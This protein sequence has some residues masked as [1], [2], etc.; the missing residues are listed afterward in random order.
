MNIRKCIIIIIPRVL[1]F[2]LTCCILA[3]KGKQA[4]LSQN[5][6]FNNNSKD[7]VD[8]YQLLK[9]PELYVDKKVTVSGILFTHEEGPCLV[10]RLPE[11]NVLELA[12]T[13]DS[14]LIVPSGLSGVWWFDSSSSGAPR[15]YS[16]TVEG[17]LLIK[18]KNHPTGNTYTKPVLEVLSAT[19]DT[20]GSSL[21]A[22]VPT[23]K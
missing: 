2:L 3:C 1:A 14:R 16:A 12:I 8:L 23:T 22:P 20:V 9:N 17:I 13:R 11:A 18:T 21:V 10:G 6:A 5:T 19:V 7:N 15:G 4:K